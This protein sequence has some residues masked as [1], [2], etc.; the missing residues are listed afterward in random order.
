MK[1]L[2]FVVLI[3]ASSSAEVY[4]SKTIL[5]ITLG[6]AFVNV[7]DIPQRLED[8]KFAPNPEMAAFLKTATIETL[9][10]SGL[11]MVATSDDTCECVPN[12]ATK[13]EAVDDDLGVNDPKAK[14]QRAFKQMNMK[15]VWRLTER[16]VRRNIY[17]AVMDSG[18]DFSDPEIASY[19]GFRRKKSGGYI[20]G[21]WNF[22]DDNSNLTSVNQHGQMVARIIAARKDNNHD[23]VGMSS[24]VRLVSLKVLPDT[25]SGSTW[26]M[27]KAMDMAV[28]IGVDI[29]SISMGAYTTKRSGEWVLGKPFKAASDQGI[30][31]VG[32]AGND[33]MLADTHYPCPLPG[34]I[35]VGA[36][37]IQGS[38]ELYSSSNY[39][40][41]VDIA[42]YGAGVY[43]G[44][45]KLAFGTS[46]ACPIVSGALAILLGMGVK[47]KYAAGIITY[48]VD[49]FASPLRPLKRNAGALN[50]LKAVKMVID[51]PV[52]RGAR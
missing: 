19:R 12:F 4:D 16:Y 40:D 48:N 36:L 34:V 39:G 7:R 31:I 22:V 26:H 25:G 50:P 14:W 9:K 35:C 2:S 21:G 11:Q 38:L 42:A 45:N 46:F 8:A 24:N 15:E 23:M 3:A 13:E 33:R 44:N 17:V 30:I 37:N 18:L 10:Y 32:A 41:Y 5:S 28:D 47:P 1:L 6:D 52:L 29:V 51:Y 43:V 27:A 49:R 20:Y